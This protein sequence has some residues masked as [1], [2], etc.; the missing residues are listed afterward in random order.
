MTEQL[1][2]ML[3]RTLPGWSNTDIAVFALLATAIFVMVVC[4]IVSR[5]TKAKFLDKFG[6]FSFLL[7][8]ALALLRKETG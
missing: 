3:E 1:Q 6:V 2:Q 8:I 5:V 4:A 7:L